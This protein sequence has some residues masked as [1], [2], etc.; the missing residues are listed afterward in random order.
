M[1][2]TVLGAGSWGTAMAL[3]LGRN[4]HEVRLLARSEADAQSLAARRENVRYLPGFVLPEVVRYAAMDG[5]EPWG[6]MLVEA[7]PSGAVLERAH[8]MAG[9]PIVCVASK[10]LGEHG[11]L[12][13]EVVLEACP[14]AQVCA[15]S[16]PNLA[17]ELAKGVPTAAVIACASEE[18]ALAARSAFH[19]GAFRVYVSSDMVG[20]EMA[21][22]L[23]NVLAIAAG[24]SDGLGYGDNTKGT[25]LSRGLGEIARIGLTRG[26]RLET[27]LG[28]A[29]VGDLFA[30]ATSRLSRNYRLGKLIAEG[31]TLEQ[32]KSEIGQV[33]EGA[34]TCASAVELAARLGVETPILDHVLRV[35]QGS[36]PAKQAVGRLMERSTI[37]EG[38]GDIPQI[39]PGREPNHAAV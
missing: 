7:L 31:A 17:A 39:V 14:G 3:L 18:A 12:L 26:A 11:V 36:L 29:G 10:G 23:K 25:L 9:Y 19:A 38:L 8:Q 15:L 16:G 32:A 37:Y 28:V 21:G 27:F 13:S 30:T 2:V 5:A 24:M 22:A 20:V 33:A 4:G 1:R 35:L 34:P 6:D